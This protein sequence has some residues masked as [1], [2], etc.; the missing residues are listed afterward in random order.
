MSK[1]G[2]TKEVIIKI[3]ND[4][5]LKAC[6]EIISHWGYSS[7]EEFI[8]EEI[9]TLVK[10]TLESNWDSLSENLEKSRRI[11]EQIA[12]KYKISSEDGA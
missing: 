1:S 10:S 4:K 9:R 12:K 3:P 2:E 5:Y 11:A 6:V 7:I 8:Q